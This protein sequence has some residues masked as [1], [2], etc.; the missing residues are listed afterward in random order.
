MEKPD[1]DFDSKSDAS[2]CSYFRSLSKTP[3]LV[4]FFDRKTFYSCHGENALFV[5][6]EYFHTT[7]VVKYL[8]SASNVASS[9][10]SNQPQGLPSVIV[11]ANMFEVVVRDL[12]QSRNLKVELY[13]SSGS[14]WSCTRRA[15]PGNMQSFEDIFLNSS[16]D[17]ASAVSMAVK[18][19]SV[20]GSIAVGVAFADTTLRTFGVCEFVDN[21]RLTNLHN[22]AI[23]IGAKEV[24]MYVDKNQPAT[25]AAYD[26]WDQLSIV[27]TERNKSTFSSS[28][29]E[30]DL[31]RLIAA[32]DVKRH[33][34][35]LDLKYAMESMGALIR[36]LELLADDSNFGTFRLFTYALGAYV[37]LDAAALRALNIL[38]SSAD[39]SKTSSLY[40]VLNRCRS[41]MGSRRMMQWIRQPLIDFGSI[42]ERHDLV[43]ALLA[44]PVLRQNIADEHIKKLPDL[45]RIIKKL[46][47]GR[48]T[49]EDAVRLYQVSLHVPR[50]VGLLESYTGG[51]SE[52]SVS[53]RFAIPLGS[54]GNDLQPLEDMI[55]KTVDMTRALQHEYVIQADFD[56]DLQD[57][58]G[59]KD[60]VLTQMQKLLREAADD[61]GFDAGKSLKLEKH[62]QHGF[63]FRVSRKDERGIRDNSKYIPLDTRKDG[64][65]FT[66]PKMRKV[67]SEYNQLCEDYSVRSV[68]LV[69]TAMD[70][71]C[72]YIPVLQTLADLFAD[73]DVFCALAQA[74]ASAPTPYVRPKMLQS[75]T[76][77]I[78][79]KQARHPSLEV[80]DGVSFIANDVDL[81]RGKTGLSIVTGPNC[82]G[83]STYIR[84]IGI[85]CLM[86]QL[87]SFVPCEF[88]ELS[89]V[90]AVMA[91]VGA[92]D[93][94]LRGISTF[95]AEMLETANILSTATE[96]SLLIIDELG[97]GTSTYDGFGLAYSIAEHILTKIG[98]YC[99]FATHFHEL[100]KLEQHK[101]GVANRHVTALTDRGD[102]LTFLYQVFPGP[103]DRSFGI[104]VAE[105]V[106]FP[107]NV[108]AAAKR[109]AD[110][111][112]SLDRSAKRR[113]SGNEFG[114]ASSR[115]DL[116]L[117]VLGSQ[118]ASS[119]ISEYI[120]EVAKLGRSQSENV[121]T[122][123]GLLQSLMNRIEQDQRPIIQKMF[124]EAKA[125][126]A[127]EQNA[128]A[129][130]VL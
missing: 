105:M 19:A 33:V 11:S 122:R 20:D 42:S 87:G 88:A 120:Q 9:P 104:H 116:D 93:S 44:D 17:F 86:A 65:L 39:T 38:P 14:S 69:K 70:V 41:A 117:Q 95:M 118:E 84:Q 119:A 49:L 22:L 114:D 40:G 5:A 46:V 71:V 92:S 28:S 6:N 78:C 36:Y 27:L 12:L 76:G 66:S 83:K 50:M 60:G 7:A 57:I 115:F 103:C 85:I 74:A 2:F 64:V 127:A 29:V 106:R 109:K 45:D 97:R 68:E 72:T 126:V 98:S 94:Q 79:M 110:E 58:Q 18:F 25:K 51:V 16:A 80:Q 90:D 112:E 59:K 31:G 3:D 125:V 130:H 82:A 4:R 52:A 91:R 35:E 67:S 111:L 47:R 13:T 15:S 102:R 30:Q 99:L 26:I 124:Q 61:L 100:T 23:Q 123:K 81:I 75:S 62:T 73:L 63:V 101:K 32:G 108:I 113:K 34:K 77:K 56:S 37:R 8:G 48:G 107:A 96:N 89:I 55:C 10:S 54:A 129:T 21:E 53:T 24:V 43:E 1:L 128:S 121:E